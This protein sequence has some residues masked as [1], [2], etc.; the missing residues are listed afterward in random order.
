MYMS[1]STNSTGSNMLCFTNTMEAMVR[2]ASAGPDPGVP[3]SPSIASGK[4]SNGVISVELAPRPKTGEQ[5]GVDVQAN[6]FKREQKF[7]RIRKDKRMDRISMQRRLESFQPPIQRMILSC[8]DE[9]PDMLKRLFCSEPAYQLVALRFLRERLAMS[10][11]EPMEEVL[12]QGV[13]PQLLLLVKG[14]YTGG[15]LYV[16]D[17][18]IRTR[19]FP[20][21][22]MLTVL[23]GRKECHDVEKYTDYGELRPDGLLSSSLQTHNQLTDKD[24]L[25]WKEFEEA[26]QATATATAT[27]RTSCQWYGGKGTGNNATIATLAAHRK[28]GTLLQYEAVSCLNLVV[29]TGTT[30][31]PPPPLLPLLPPLPPLLYH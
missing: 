4:K 30:S 21:N 11:N 1:M 10:Y 28:I 3:W 23:D 16:L 25:A 6:K 2:S 9:L 29:T 17:P 14:V 13:V 7:S 27:V 8:A 31:A 12:S 15:E 24:A 18:N 22:S 19:E 20:E 5:R 26:M